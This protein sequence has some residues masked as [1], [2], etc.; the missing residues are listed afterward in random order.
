MTGEVVVVDRHWYL[1]VNKFARSTTWA[2]SFMGAYFDRVA[3]PVGAGLLVLA[4]LVLLA[5]W[6]ARRQPER[7]VAVVWS[8]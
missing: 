3:L 8:G 1:E 5:W 7:V 4:A 2:H 6:S